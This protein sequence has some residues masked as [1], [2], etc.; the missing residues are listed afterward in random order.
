MKLH[1]N[2]IFFA[3]KLRHEQHV[4]LRHDVIFALLFYFDRYINLGSADKRYYGVL[5]EATR[6]KI[7]EGHR[8]QPR[9]ASGTRPKRLVI[10]LTLVLISYFVFGR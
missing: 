9:Q 2:M 4:T 6:W 7:G 5:Q 8:L 3:C 10:Q 1:H